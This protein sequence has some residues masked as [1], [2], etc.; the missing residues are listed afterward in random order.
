MSAGITGQWRPWRLLSEG[1]R[2]RCSRLQQ[3]DQ[4]NGAQHIHAGRASGAI[5]MPRTRSSPRDGRRDR[6]GEERRGES[7]SARFSAVRALWLGTPAFEASGSEL[8]STDR[9]IVVGTGTGVAAADCCGYQTLVCLPVVE[10]EP[11]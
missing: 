5:A 10:F 1:N 7:G 8:V 11:I 2:I 3:A 9:A 6:I 4:C